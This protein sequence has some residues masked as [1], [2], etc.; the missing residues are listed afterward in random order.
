MA[1]TLSDPCSCWVIPID[2]TSTAV[3]AERVHAG[4]AL[5]VGAGRTRLPFEV[6]EG[7]AFEHRFQ[8]LVEAFGVLTHELAVDPAL[9]EQ[10]LH[11]AVD[12]RDVASGVHARRTRRSS[13]CRT[14]RSRRCSAPSSGRGP[15]R[16]SG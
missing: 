13:S 5:H 4:E 9:G 3:R 12:E 14:S 2:Q 16:A 10:H 6:G 7:L 1:A 11:D 8:Q 15:A